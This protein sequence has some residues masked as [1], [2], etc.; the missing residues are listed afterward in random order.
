[1]QP[2]VGSWA[3]TLSATAS[4]FQEALRERMSP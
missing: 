1:M 2:I 4:L 3:T